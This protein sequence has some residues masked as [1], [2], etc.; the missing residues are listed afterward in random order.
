V[1]RFV[2]LSCLGAAVLLAQQPSSDLEKTFERAERA[3]SE[4]RYSDAEVSYRELVKLSPGTAEVYGRLGLTYFQEGKFEDAVPVLRRALKLKPNLPN[5]DVLL[6]MCLSELGQYNEALPGLEKGFRAGDEPLKRASGLQLMRAYTGLARDSKAVETALQL[7]A[8]FPKDSEI[9]YHTSKIYANF[10]YLKLRNLADV[11]PNSIWRHQAAGEAYE[12]SA[13]YD[14]ASTEYHEVLRLDPNRHGIHYRIGR[15][16]LLRSRSGQSNSQAEALTEFE[17][18]IALDPT[19]ANAAYEAAE[20][21]RKSGQ[22]EK[23]R[24]L[25]AKAVDH[26][27]DFEEAQLGLS[28]VLIALGQPAEAVPHLQKAI[29]LKPDDEVSYYRLSLAYKALGNAPEQQ[30]A[31]EHYKDLHVHKANQPVLET[32]LQRAEITKQEVDEP[33]A[34]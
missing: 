3:L 6:A 26:Y 31:I 33:G 22:L 20:I 18:E 4:H 32:D 24:D 34:Q 13:N 17:Q 19:N 9:L 25:F 16:L 10:A 21:C 27:P 8:A 30:K 11:A 1:R 7:N 12:S 23:A 15:V 28:G 5:T 14:L 29:V 2:C